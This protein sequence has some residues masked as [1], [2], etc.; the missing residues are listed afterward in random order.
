M[1][2]YVYMT[3]HQSRIHFSGNIDD[4]YKYL[5]FILQ[6]FSIRSKLRS[7]GVDMKSSAQRITLLIFNHP[8]S[9]S[10]GS[11]GGTQTS[12]R[13][14]LPFKGLSNLPLQ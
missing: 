8:S 13:N 1:Y 6:D 14:Y 4:S 5:N 2:M 3:S 7:N 10:I 9:I 11:N 12:I